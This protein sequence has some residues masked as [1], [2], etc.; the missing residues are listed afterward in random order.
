[1]KAHDGNYGNELADYL[2]KKAACSSEA[3]IAYIKTPKSAVISELKEKCTGVAKRM[4]RLNQGRI[5]KN[6]LPYSKRQYI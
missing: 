2:A 3:D 6:I 1:M 5:N 4:G